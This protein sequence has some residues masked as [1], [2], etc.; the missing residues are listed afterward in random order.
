MAYCRESMRQV[1]NIYYYNK[2]P[3]Y[4]IQYTHKRDNF[5]RNLRN[6]L[7]T[8]DNDFAK[9]CNIRE[10]LNC[11]YTIGLIGIQKESGIK[12][13]TPTAPS[14]TVLD[15]NDNIQFCIYPLFRK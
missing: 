6:L 4:Y 11:M 15:Y 8:A 7:N 12:Y 1:V 10:L 13:A 2:Q 3:T 9:E 5:F 14:L